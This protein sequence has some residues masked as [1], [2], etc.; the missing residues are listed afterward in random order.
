MDAGNYLSL[1]AIMIAINASSIALLLASFKKDSRKLKKNFEANHKNT[2]YIQSIVDCI[3]EL[4]DYQEKREKLYQSAVSK[5]LLDTDK[6]AYQK[7]L[8]SL[9]LI[10]RP[11]RRKKNE[12]MLHSSDLVK[13]ESACKQLAFAYGNA[14][15]LEIMKLL[16]EVKIN[17]E[18]DYN[19]FTKELKNELEKK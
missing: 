16:Q 13:C 18:L 4:M 14:H 10:H 1:V 12:L 5:L 9:Q 3:T 15:S 17:N 2:I 7:L 11:L 6:F 19:Y 8:D